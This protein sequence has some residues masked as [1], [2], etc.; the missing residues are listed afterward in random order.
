M[1]EESG[2]IRIRIRR[3]SCFSLYMVQCDFSFC[4]Q[5]SCFNGLEW[6]FGVTLGFSRVSWICLK[7]QTSMPD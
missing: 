5:D 4:H 2:G 6:C 3:G 7:Q 1:V